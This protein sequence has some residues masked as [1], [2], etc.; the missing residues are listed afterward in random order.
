[1]NGEDY[2]IV[3]VEKRFGREK[4]DTLSFSGAKLRV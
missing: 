1:M 2:R 3:A 4:G